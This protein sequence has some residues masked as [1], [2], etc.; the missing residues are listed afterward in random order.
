V[1]IGGRHLELVRAT[2]HEAGYQACQGTRGGADRCWSGCIGYGV[3]R[4]AGP[5]VG[6]RLP[7]D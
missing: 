3:G 5:T 2:V 7:A 1:D 4:D 6:R